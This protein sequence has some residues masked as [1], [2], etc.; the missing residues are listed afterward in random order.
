MK[1]IPK[2]LRKSSLDSN[3]SLY[4]TPN[5]NIS[6]LWIYRILVKGEGYKTFLRQNDFSD[7]K[8]AESLDLGDYIFN[9][10]L[11]I[12]NLLEIKNKLFK[13]ADKVEKNRLNFLYQDSIFKKNIENLS[14]TIGLTTIESDILLFCATVKMDS[15]LE[16][17]TDV[18]GDLSVRDIERILGICLEYSE[19]DVRNAL[20][21]DGRLSSSGLL[22]IDLTGSYRYS[23]KIDLLEGLID[24]LHINGNDPEQ[25]LKNIIFLSK[26]AKL[27]IS[28]YS[29]IQDE[30]NLLSGYLNQVTLDKSSGINILIYGVPG[31]GKT[32][33]VKTIAQHCNLE[34]FEVASE[35]TSDAP[36]DT[37]GRFRAFRLGQILCASK[38][39]PAIMFDE[40][41]DVFINKNNY[42]AHSNNSGRKCWINHLLENNA[43]PSFWISNSIDAIDPAFIR[44]FD[45]VLKMDSPPRKVREEL[46]L[47]YFRDL[48]VSQE[49]VKM[50]SE[51]ETLLPALIERS[52][53][54][55]NKSSLNISQE[56]T[57]HALETLLGNTVEAMGYKPLSIQKKQVGLSYR[58]DLLNTDFAVE[59]ICEGLKE[60]RQGRLCLYGPPGTGKTA[61]GKY[62]STALGMPLISKKASD[63]TSPYLGES[64]QNMAA[65]F[66]QA[67]DENAILMLD[68]ADTFLSERK[69]AQRSWEVSAV[70]EMLTQ[71]ESFEGI[72]IAS[73]NFMESLDS[74]A[75]RRF[76]IKLKFDYLNFEQIFIMFEELLNQT[77][78]LLESNAICEL[79]KL[80]FVT[81][82][83]FAV[84]KR[85]LKF[86]KI[87]TTQALLDM[88]K[89]ECAY[90]EESRVNSI[91]F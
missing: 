16:A 24:R 53:K 22:N 32:E 29:Q 75:M 12:F 7:D 6:T 23:Q 4:Q 78:L 41:E 5:D 2:F 14:N 59:S 20:L 69:N 8:L 56:K 91:G 50:M 39:R 67:K 30:I 18:L 84:I 17:A 3:I 40:I 60:F 55:L 25:I 88:I 45:F 87:I 26:P 72:F 85:K 77:N 73:T 57:E 10:E 48:P 37:D 63:I 89:H 36:L 49:W 9:D 65:M 34:L 44:R 83:D 81:P 52:A 33:F 43:V 47:E 76:D 70:N 74:A 35:S 64:E 54:V 11:K 51:N 38:N 1:N 15:L 28:K 61:F 71:M 80:K 19:H 31:S 27:S 66:K 42:R 46:L 21:S 90:K 62:L 13:Q 86:S 82:G 79:K 58:L 68:E